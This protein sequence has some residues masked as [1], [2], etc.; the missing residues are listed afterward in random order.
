MDVRGRPVLRGKP[1]FSSD[2]L[3]RQPLG[4]E[5]PLF[6]S[7]EGRWSSRRLLEFL[8]LLEAAQR[9]PGAPRVT[10]SSSVGGWP[11]LLQGCGPIDVRVPLRGPGGL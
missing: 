4:A 3:N 10:G 11:D 9:G 5:R 8:L 7:P 2:R 1:S 6:L